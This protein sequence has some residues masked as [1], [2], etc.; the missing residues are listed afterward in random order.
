[1]ILLKSGAQNYQRGKEHIVFKRWA[2]ESDRPALTS[3]S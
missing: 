1:M 3:S 2:L